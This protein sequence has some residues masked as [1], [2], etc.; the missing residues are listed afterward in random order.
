MKQK[1]LTY[2]FL[3]EIHVVE[4]C[5]AGRCKSFV[6]VTIYSAMWY[7]LWDVQFV[8]LNTNDYMMR[9]LTVS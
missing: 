6:R 9:P 4:M 7:Y 2:L 8:Y 1:L 5:E 3:N